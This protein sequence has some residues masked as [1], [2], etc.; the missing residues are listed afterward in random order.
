ME[1]T[2]PPV[3]GPPSE[4]LS[5]D[6]ISRRE[7]LAAKHAKKTE[8]KL[9]KKL[10]QGIKTLTK[11]EG[12]SID[13]LITDE[14]TETLI[15]LHFGLGSEEDFS[16]LTEYL[17]DKGNCKLEIHPGYPY[18]TLKFESQQ[19]AS[20]LVESITKK[21]ENKAANSVELNYSGKIRNTFFFFTKLQPQEIGSQLENEIPNATTETDIPGLII[22]EN[23]VTEAQEQDLLATIDKQPWTSIKNRR[24]QHYGYEF[25]YKGDHK[26]SIDTTCN[27]GGLPA[28]TNALT[29]QLNTACDPHNKG[30][31][32]KILFAEFGE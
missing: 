6:E 8:F 25:Q 29:L 22:I 23:F 19:L 30:F 28:W 16:T 15:V 4:T 3:P 31:D 20:D 13:E 7:K 32:G 24:I 14:P 1:Q 21:V 2:P 27:L 26:N 11:N 9:N 18:G 12:K 10:S 5:A 17:E